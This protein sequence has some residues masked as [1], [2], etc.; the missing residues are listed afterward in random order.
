MRKVIC[1]A[2]SVVIL[3]AAIKAVSSS[4][5]VTN[6][7]WYETA[8]DFVSENGIMPGYDDT[9]DPAKPITRAEYV[10]ALY[11][12]SK[13][14]SYGFTVS[15]TDVSSE[16]TFYNAIGWAKKTILQAV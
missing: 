10:E 16:S 8:I 13:E 9:F 5:D 11:K 3:S 15:F 7:A 4:A 6:D 12:A 1:L 2:L 14:I